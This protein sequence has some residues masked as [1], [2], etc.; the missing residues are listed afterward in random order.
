VPAA[1]AAVGT[2][3]DI[4]GIMIVMVAEHW[5]GRRWAAQHV[6]NVSGLPLSSLSG[7]SCPVPAACAAVGTSGNFDQPQVALAGWWHGKNW[8]IQRVASPAGAAGGS[9]S[10]VSCRSARMCMAVGFYQASSLSDVPESARWNGTRWVI[11]PL[12]VHF[13]RAPRR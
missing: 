9:L 2:S 8:V 3:S 7:V 1:C 6:D 10:S 5:N 13:P 11:A 4:D 12:P